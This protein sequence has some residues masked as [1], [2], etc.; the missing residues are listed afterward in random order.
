MP[1]EAEK[2]QIKKDAKARAKAQKEQ[3]QVDEAQVEA[4][5]QDAEEA[6]SGQAVQ[7]MPVTE[8]VGEALE[9]YGPYDEPRVVPTS[10]GEN[11]VPFR[12][13]LFFVEV[14]AFDPKINRIVR[15]MK[16]THRMATKAEMAPILERRAKKKAAMAGR[17]V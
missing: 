4:F 15:R 11:Q 9:E 12:K 7:P 3:V 2:A 5:R 10:Q 8:A 14:E 1:T 6:M 16:P 17:T 13:V